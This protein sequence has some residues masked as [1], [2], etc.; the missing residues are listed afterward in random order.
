MRTTLLTGLAVLSLAA[1]DQTTTPGITREDEPKLTQEYAEFRATQVEHVRYHL[2]VELDPSLD[3]FSGENRISFDLR[4][5]L[6][7]L[8][9]DFSGGE[10]FGVSVNGADVDASYNDSFITVAATA[11]KVGPNEIVVR[12]KHAWSDDGSGLYRY[13]DP[14]DGKTYLYTDFEPYDANL[15][16]PLFDQPDIKGRF[17]LSVTTPDNWHVVSTGR[18]TSIEPATESTRTWLFPETLPIPTYVM[19]LHAGPYAVWEDD[20]FRIPLRLFARQSMAD[21]VA[22]DTDM[23]FEVTRVGLD[24]FEEYFGVGYP[25]G[26]YDQLIVP[27]FNASAMENAAAVTFSERS[28]IQR[29]GWSYKE[30]KRLSM[31][32]FHEM[33]HMW[34][35]D[36]VTMKWWNGLWLNE[37]FAEFMGYQAAAAKLGIDDAWEGFF[38][39]R[40]YRA[41]WLDQ[42]STTHPVETPVPD[43]E[44]VGANFDMISYAKGAAVLRQIEFRLGQDVFR[45]GINTYLERHAEGNAELQDFVVALAEA[46]GTDLD[47]WAQEWLHTAGANTVEARYSC[48]DGLVTDFAL[49]Q[50]APDDYPILRTQKVQVGF[51]RD[52]DG[53]VVTDAVITVT[54]SGA[55]TDVPGAVGKACPDL[56]YPNYQ[57][58]GYLLVKLDPRTRDNLDSMIGRVDDDFQRVMFWQTL[59]DNVRFAQ[60]P[61]TDY[62]DAVFAA[63]AQ[64]DNLNNVDQI[65]AFVGSAINYLRN[66]QDKGA[67]ALATYR[68]KA[69]SITWANVERTRGD[70]Q[71]T[72]LDR[73]LEFVSGESELERLVGMLSGDIEIPGRELDQGRRWKAL[74]ALSA[75]GHEL[76]DNL[77]SLEKKRD[78]SD[79]GRRA[80]LQVEAARPDIEVKRA[81][82]ADVLNKESDNSYAMQRLAMRVLFPPGQEDLHEELADKIL[83][84]ILQNEKDADP[85]FYSRARGFAVYLMPTD[86]TKA[87]VARLKSAIAA[88]QNSRA[89]IKDYVIERHEDDALCVKRAAL[90]R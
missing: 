26:K 9:I 47:V 57:D 86:C 17:A 53:V 71:T 56:V 79:K 5:N 15:A 38:L 6:S 74:L 41:Y 73:Y 19:S 49:L 89:S 77:L 64:E 29:D 81:I 8:T 76:V 45:R 87:S 11:L 65:Y 54:Y 60:I 35:G 18:E 39:D 20:D 14:G 66:M 62:L 24:F 32:I 48:T 40:K 69:E 83:Q 85:S 1:C 31:V 51:F 46:S 43:T 37:T 59:W 21:L 68:P 22:P 78:P 28:F 84:H 75:E 90:L 30:K 3:Y 23:W 33:A 36:L 4:D 80:A 63:A 58:M 70:L 44:S 67:E 72:Y 42:R 50:S 7:D 55:T 16:F 10:V 2:T 13:D 34:F 52:V 61:V 12:F 27:D 82:I 25:F 88:H